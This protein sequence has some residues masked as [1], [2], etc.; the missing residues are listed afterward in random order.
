[1]MNFVPLGERQQVRCELIQ[2]S[3]SDRVKELLVRLQKRHG[4]FLMQL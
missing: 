4:E 1:M 3:E 2:L